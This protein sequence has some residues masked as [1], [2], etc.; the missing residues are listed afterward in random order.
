[1][2]AGAGLPATCSCGW[3]V[4]AETYDEAHNLARK[5]VLDMGHGSVQ[6]NVRIGNNIRGDFDDD[7]D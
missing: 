7:T 6:G 3:S 4:M 2:S 1:M 5:H